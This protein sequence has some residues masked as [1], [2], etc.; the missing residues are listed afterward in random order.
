MGSPLYFPR[1]VVLTPLEQR[2]VAS[3]DCPV[4]YPHH[5]VTEA[6]KRRLTESTK[7]NRISTINSADIILP[8]PSL[9]YLIATEGLGSERTVQDY[10]EGGDEKSHNGRL[11]RFVKDTQNNSNLPHGL[12]EKMK[13][14]ATVCSV[15][16]AKRDGSFVW[17]VYDTRP[18]FFDDPFGVHPESDMVLVHG[19]SEKGHIIIR[20]ANKEDIELFKGLPWVSE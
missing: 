1:D 2:Y 12:V 10:F 16:L 7:Q 9:A 5:D 6:W 11:V 14:H 3:C 8:F 18:N 19:R 15:K 13:Y 20:E 17:S 4:D